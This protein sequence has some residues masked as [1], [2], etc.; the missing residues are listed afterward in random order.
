MTTVLILGGLG[1]DATRHLLPYLTSPSSSISSDLRP[2]FI[3]VVDKYLAIPAAG[4][5]TTY[6]DADAREALKTGTEKGTVEYVQ[7]NLLTDATRE[8]AF[9]LP[10]KFGGPDKGFSFVFD[11]TGE[12]DFQ[13]PEIVH[14]E[15][16]LRL[17]LL[18]GR[19]AVAHKVGSYVRL[20]QPFYKLKDEKKGVKVGDKA[21][22]VSEP[23]GTL[24]GWW[25][26][27]ARGLAKIEGLNLALIRPALFYGPYTLSGLT[28]RALIGEVYRF[29]N[30]KLEFL[31]AESLPQNTIHS[32]DFASA[33]VSAAAWAS[34][35]GSRSSILATHS[36][37]LPSTL[38]S[39][40]QVSALADLGAATKEDG[41]IRAAVFN[42]V[43]DGETTQ[44]EVAKVIEEVVGVKSGFHGGVISAFAKLNMTDV[45]EDV[46]DKHL[47]GWSSLLQAS[48][49]PISS[50]V[51][52]SP[53]VPLDLLAPNPISFSNAP[54]K[55]LTGWAPK[56]KLDAA[57]VRDTVEKF[58]KEGNWPN[59]KP[60]K[61]K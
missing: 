3:R 14:L 35:L 53:F 15:R 52:I 9:T 44:K 60:Q 30:E 11:M 43:D 1:Q 4:A 6:V 5:Y 25:H 57:T 12:Q 41:E 46:N 18:L 59:A 26:E 16:T 21:A 10:D 48:S 31:W 23:W 33:C 61:K 2:V 36:E 27:A 37:V 29:Q 47:E 34:K 42:A 49:P 19:S 56:H 8:K 58:R 7:G 22:G 55:E 17:A 32:A 39:S 50:S 38:S 13:A 45:V 28:P 51:P 24:A 54:L 40:S 20:L